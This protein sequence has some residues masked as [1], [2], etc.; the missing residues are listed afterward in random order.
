MKNTTRKHFN[1]MAARYAKS[2]GVGSVFEQFSVLPEIEQ[3][4]QDKIVEQSTF[5]P[6]INTFIVDEMEGE[7]IMG[8]ASGP[9][10]GRIDTSVDGQERV[11]KNLLGL[12]SYKYKLYQTNSDVYMR[13]ATMD[14]WAKFKDF[15]ERYAR[16]VQE[17]IAN[18]R[19]LIG[20]YGE[21]AATDTDI[22]TNPELRT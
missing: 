3:Q 16:Y 4:L 15:A 12:E 14:A 10:S 18:D 17:R 6:L 5:L 9:V 20:W 2:Y 13:Y 21:S 11:P 22:A 8:S 19:E 1:N 7:N